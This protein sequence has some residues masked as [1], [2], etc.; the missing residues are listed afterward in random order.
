MIAVRLSTWRSANWTPQGRGSGGVFAYP[1]T[2]VRYG[3]IMDAP[4]DAKVFRLWGHG[5]LP[6]F[7]EVRRPDPVPVHAGCAA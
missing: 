4:D 1:I 5:R 6:G 7:A 3:H 2:Q